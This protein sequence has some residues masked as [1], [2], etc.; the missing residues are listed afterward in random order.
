[1]KIIKEKS[2]EYKGQKYFKYKINIPEMI[3]SRAKLKAGDELE[4]TAEN[5]KILLHKKIAKG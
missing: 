4:V 1:M 5:E 3:L 2:R